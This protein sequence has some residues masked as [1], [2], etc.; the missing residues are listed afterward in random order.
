MSNASCGLLL[1]CMM[2]CRL[3]GTVP[4]ATT[5]LPDKTPRLCAA[6]NSRTVGRGT[7]SWIIVAVATFLVGALVATVVIIAFM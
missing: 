2:L 5:T 3:A 4:F 7:G 6:S 1:Y